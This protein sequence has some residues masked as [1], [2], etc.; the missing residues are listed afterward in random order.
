MEGAGLFESFL[1][2]RFRSGVR[3]LLSL[4]SL[5]VFLS[6]KLVHVRDARSTEHLLEYNQIHIFLLLFQEVEILFF[7]VV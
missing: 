7:Q 2:D 4:G 1:D 3:V 5:R 6:E